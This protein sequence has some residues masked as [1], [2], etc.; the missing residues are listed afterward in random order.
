MNSRICLRTVDDSTINI[1]MHINIIIITIIIQVY[2]IEQLKIRH[3]YLEEAR[4]CR[5]WRRS[6]WGQSFRAAAEQ[7]WRSVGRLHRSRQCSPRSESPGS[8]WL[9]SRHHI[10]TGWSKK[11]RHYQT[12]NKSHHQNIGSQPGGKLTKFGNGEG[13]NFLS[14]KSRLFILCVFKRWV[15]FTY[16]RCLVM[17]EDPSAKQNPEL[18]NWHGKNRPNRRFN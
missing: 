10:Q 1:V 6:D 4:R 12:I 14:I 11:I 16:L 3:G 13:T 5:E 17:R 15:S 2:Y 7:N 18:R 9:H 8:E